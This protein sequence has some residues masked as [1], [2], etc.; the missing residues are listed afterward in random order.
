[1]AKKNL[2]TV[3]LLAAAALAV[4]TLACSSLQVGVVTP[5]P[6]GAVQ[7]VA[8]DDNASSAEEE[9][10]GEAAEEDVPASL[11]AVAWLGHIASAP[12]GSQYDDILI[13]SPEGTGEYGLV[14]ATP[15]LEAEIRTLR[16]GEGPQKNVHL[17]GTFSCSGQDYNGCQLVADRLQYGPTMAEEEIINWTG[18]IRGF[19]FN[20]G[21]TYGF[22]LVGQV[23]MSYGIYASQDPSLQAKIESLR[24]TGS[25]IQISGKL[26]VGFPD[27]NSTRIEVSSLQ[28]LDAGT[29][30]QP[31]QET[32]DPTE[33][34]LV[35]TSSRYGYQIKYPEGAE[36]NLIGP[37]GFSTDALPDGMT[38]EEY[39]DALNKE[40][41][42]QL[43]VEI[44]Y[45]L[46]FVYISAPPNNM[47]D[48][49]VLCGVSG[50]GVGELKDQVRNVEVGGRVY[51]AS[52]TEYIGSSPAGETLDRHSD[53]FRID[54]EDGTRIIYGATP[55]YDATYQDYLMKTRDTLEQIIGTF[56]VV[57]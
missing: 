46:G 22:E 15:E 44:K 20:M 53:T 8:A 56:Q 41:T 14:G 25:L 40:Y 43:C 51:V 26:L 23:P 50:Y 54:L 36:I 32:F 45:S 5:T 16:D 18:T 13:L 37:M 33:G 39:L 11:A 17:W 35:F 34:W 9:T 21:P 38:P 4:S 12:E 29:E 52:G 47:G 55:R 19:D 3:F 27:V 2:I 1:M 7:P 10:Q 48:P 24:D 42:N 49:L 57:Q 30:E 28:V 31:T 6:D